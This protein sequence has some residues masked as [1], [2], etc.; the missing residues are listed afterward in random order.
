M[1]VVV[2]LVVVVVMYFIIFPLRYWRWRA[3]IMGLTPCPTWV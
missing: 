3:G 2:V 1:D